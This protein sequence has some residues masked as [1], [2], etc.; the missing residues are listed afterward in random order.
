MKNRHFWRFFEKKNP[1][2]GPSKGRD[3]LRA[4]DL[5]PRKTWTGARS[6]D[7]VA[8][9]NEIL[10]SPEKPHRA[11]ASLSEPNFSIFARKLK[12]KNSSDRS[13][14][15]AGFG[16]NLWFRTFSIWASKPLKTYPWTTKTQLG[17]FFRVPDLLGPQIRQ[18]NC[19]FCDLSQKSGKILDFPRIQANS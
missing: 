5:G 19:L 16:R 18:Q 6:Q 15:T 12:N 1:K 17:I 8:R 2:K 4:Q 3:H 9:P 11:S 10:E 13:P 14:K 7:S